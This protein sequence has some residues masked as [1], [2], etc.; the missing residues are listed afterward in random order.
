MQL[1][2]FRTIDQRNALYGQ[3]K[4]QIRPSRVGLNTL[5]LRRWCESK[6]GPQIQWVDTDYGAMTRQDNIHYK[7]TKRQRGAPTLIYLKDEAEALMF[8]LSWSP[9]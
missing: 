6:W 4:Y 8:S 7:F 1:K 9:K 3:F 5:E 2:W